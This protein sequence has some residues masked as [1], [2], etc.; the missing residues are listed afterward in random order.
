MK[1]PRLS[2]LA[3]AKSYDTCLFYSQNAPPQCAEMLLG[4]R[5][6]P[7]KKTFFQSW[8]R[9]KFTYDSEFAMTKQTGNY[10]L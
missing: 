7:A 4:E 3:A 9:H 5:D 6:F 1:I 2:S 8:G 10:R